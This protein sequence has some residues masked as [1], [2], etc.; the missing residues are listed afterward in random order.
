VQQLRAASFTTF[1]R[2]EHRGITILAVHV[3]NRFQ[4]MLK[5]ARN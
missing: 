5:K 1:I 3:N 4:A 2:C